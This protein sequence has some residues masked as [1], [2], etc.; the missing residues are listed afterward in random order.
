M[1]HASRGFGVK[2]DLGEELG[3]ALLPL[4]GSRMLKRRVFRVRVW[5]L[6]RMQWLPC[7]C[8]RSE[9]GAGRL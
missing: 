4:E 6:G 2:K 3:F 7:S 5:V 1:Q 8:D 9:R